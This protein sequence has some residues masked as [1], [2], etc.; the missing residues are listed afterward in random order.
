MAEVEELKNQKR[1]AEVRK[2]VVATLIWLLLVS[3]NICRILK[4]KHFVKNVCRILRN[5]VKFIFLTKVIGILFQ[6]LHRDSLP[7]SSVQQQKL[8]V[9]EVCAAYLS[10]YDNDRRYNIC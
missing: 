7:S 5:F 8:R 2:L 9:C 1:M 3:R 10:L 4:I 6:D